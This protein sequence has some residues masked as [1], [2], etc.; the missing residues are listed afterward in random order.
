MSN[1]SD[2]GYI[3]FS[4]DWQLSEPFSSIAIEP[5]NQ[6]RQYLY[7]AHLVGAYSDGIGFGNVSQRIDQTQF[8]ISGSKTGNFQKLNHQ[9]YAKVNRY[10]IE[11]NQVWCTGPIIA[12]S[13]S[14][15]HA[16]IYQEVAE[17][18]AV[19]HVHH[20]ELW[21]RVLYKIPT[22]NQSAAYGTPEMAAEIARLIRESNVLET[23]V[24]AM[25]GHKEG[26]I[27]FGQTLEEAG[28]VILNLLKQEGL[29]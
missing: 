2:E 20:L 25:G 26:L 17:V 27:S 28:K 23:K 18:Q 10:E 13:E 12:S 15:S 29:S 5:L 9:H 22:T 8:F 6:W 19:F 16:T 24:F 14:M 1:I 3:K 11:Q 4:C 21:E 7:D